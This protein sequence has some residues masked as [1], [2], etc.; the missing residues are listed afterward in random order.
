MAPSF[1]L[2]HRKD[3][4]M[5][6]SVTDQIGI[7]DVLREDYSIRPCWNLGTLCGRVA[8]TRSHVALQ[9]QVHL[10]HVRLSSHLHGKLHAR[11]LS[12]IKRT[13]NQ[14]LFQLQ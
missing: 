9:I 3:L 10:L 4:T 13:A 1:A 5:K 6:P 7:V 8:Q 14:Q 11:H 12:H 2:P